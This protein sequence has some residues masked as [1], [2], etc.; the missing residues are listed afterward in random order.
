MTTKRQFVAIF[1][2]LLMLVSVSGM[3]FAEKSVVEVPFDSHGQSCWFDE[4]AV[5]YHCTWQGYQEVFTV[6]DLMKYKSLLTEQRFNEEI[7]Q[8]NEAALA[9]IEVEQAKLSPNEKKI[10]EFERLLDMGVATAQQSVHMNLLKNLDTCLQ[11]MDAN[12]AP[13]QTAREITKS[14]FNNWKLNNIEYTGQVLDIVLAIEECRAQTHVFKLG[15]GYANFPTGD[16]D[17]QFSLADV[18]TPDVQAINFADFTSTTTQVNSSL[19][20]DSGQHSNQYKE[21]FGCE[22]LYDGKTA[23][24]IRL[25]NEQR[26]GTSGEIN[27]QSLVLDDYHDFLSTYGNKFATAED[28]KVQ[29]DIAFPIAEEWKESN[30]FYQNK[31]KHED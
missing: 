6:E 14:S 24:D 15:V 20:C 5:E 18:Y 26:F 28:K 8:L 23:E 21:Q 11:G 2:A 30:N 17:Y 3:A 12:T 13:F 10:Q 7:K 9:A 1:I 16:D 4:I 27:Y 31:L 19:I 29:E 22:I 25:E